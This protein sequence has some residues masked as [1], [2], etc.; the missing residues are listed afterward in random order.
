MQQED[1]EDEDED[2]EEDPTYLPPKKK[3][4]KSTSPAPGTKKVRPEIFDA[5]DYEEGL[6]DLDE[7]SSDSYESD[8]SDED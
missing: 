1:D 2:E 8:E 3:R 4:I 7:F 6:F 5:P